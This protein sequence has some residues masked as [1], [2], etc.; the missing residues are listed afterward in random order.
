GAQVTPE[1]WLWTGAAELI[2]F[3]G[4]DVQPLRQRIHTLAEGHLPIVQYSVGRDGL[5]YEIVMFGATLDGGTEGNLI[6]FVRVRVCNPGEASAPATFAAAIRADGPNVCEGMRQSFNVLG[7]VYELGPSY[8]ARDGAIV[9]TFSEVPSPRRFIVPDREEP[10]PI[11]ASEEFVTRRTPVCMVR[12]DFTLPAGGTQDIYLK[13][14]YYPVPIDSPEAKAL[15]EARFE[16]YLTRTREWWRNYLATGAQIELPEEKVVDAWRAGLVYA[17]IARDKVGEDYIA[18]VNEFQYDAFWV[19]DGAYIVAS[20]DFYGRHDWAAQSLD[21]FL[22]QQQP[23]GIMYQPP[24]LDGFGQSLWAMGNH[25]RLTGDMEFARR[26]YP[27]LA[28]HARGVLEKVRTD[29]LGLIPP[30]PPYDNEAINGHYTGHSLWFLTGLRDVI[31][32]A[33]ALGEKEDAAQ[34]RAWFDEYRGRFLSK[35]AEVAVKTGGYLPPGLDAGPGCDWGN[36]LL[37]YPRGGVPS[38]GVFDPTDPVVAATVDTVRTRKYAEGI[39]TYGPGLAVHGLHHYVTIKL[40]QNL[41]NMNRQRDCL[42]DFYG[43]LVHTSSTHAG[44]EMGMAPWDNR[45]PGG[46]L[47]PHGWSAAMY[48]GLL[49]NMLVREWEGHLHLFTALSPAWVK[50]GAHIAIRGMPTEFGTVTA[51]TEVGAT[52]W[53]IRL[54][55]AWRTPPLDIVVHIPWFAH[56]RSASADGR[57]VAVMDASFGEGQQ[58][59]VPA[60]T[61]ELVVRW[62]LENVPDISYEAAVGAW[63]AENRRRFDEYVAAGGQPEPLWPEGRLLMTREER[64]DAWVE[65]QDQVGIAVGCSAVASHSEEGHP[66]SHAVDGDASRSSYWGAT[67]YPAWWQVDLGSAKRLGVIRVVT[68]WDEGFERRYYQFRVLVSEDGQTW[69][70]VGD[71]SENTEPAAPR[72]V[73]FRVGGR[74]ARYL[75]VEMLKNS[76]NIG[77]HLVEVMVFSADEVPVVEPPRESFTVWAAEEQSGTQ[78]QDFP[79]WGFV[80]AERIVLQGARIRRAAGRVR[81]VFRAG[82]EEGVAI[83]DV[84]LS[85]TDPRDAADIIASSRVPVTFAGATTVELPPDNAVESDWVRCELVPGQDYSV[86]FSVLK[87]GGATIWPDKNTRRFETDSSAARSAKW[88]T[89]G[90]AATYNIYFLERVEGGE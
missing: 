40:T 41:V 19:R 90:A 11:K 31:A 68:Y 48:N 49:R 36:L 14:P 23:D 55:A 50:P 16:D 32:I 85:R 66:P 52:Q 39:M 56:A 65:M 57:P 5:V 27:Y 76:A 84:S 17:S 83:G 60:S 26:V 1:G 18:K 22:K 61:R 25:W 33:D 62:R 24:Q 70:Q 82:K 28:S 38:R 46:N 71:M 58:T 64:R 34:F 15:R 77:V 29:P 3:A 89:V 2:F 81:L 7:A 37:T 69:Q 21:F 44:F 43:W 45:D 20:F 72:G 75:R 63:K 86:T 54:R 88:S 47:P 30:A 80:G 53:R 59:V 12:Y 51:E 35:V 9:Y 73:D 6:C 79:S 8:A 78:G 13:M 10:G 4:A 67:P 74:K 42:A 87:T